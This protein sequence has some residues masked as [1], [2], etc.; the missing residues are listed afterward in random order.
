MLGGD[1]DGIDTNGLVAV[2]VLDGYLT[3][4]IGAQVSHL[5]ALLANMRKGIDYRMRHIE[6]ERHVV[7]RLCGGITEHHTL[8]A[9]TLRHA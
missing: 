5:P 1:N 9:R 8:V 4:G 7:L 2:V 6:R 3:L